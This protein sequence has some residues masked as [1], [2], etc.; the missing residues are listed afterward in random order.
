MELKLKT[1]SLKEIIRI[2][3]SNNID[4][5]NA[6]IKTKIWEDIRKPDEPIVKLYLKYKK[7]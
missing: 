7:P 1:T 6:K 2:C 5:N 4:I 3:K